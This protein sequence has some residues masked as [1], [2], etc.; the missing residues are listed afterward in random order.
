MGE[1][2]LVGRSLPFL[3]SLSYCTFWNR[4]LSIKAF[5]ALLISVCYLE[6]IFSCFIEGLIST[7]GYVSAGGSPGRQEYVITGTIGPIAFTKGWGGGGLGEGVS[8]WVWGQGSAGV[9]EG[10]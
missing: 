8:R 2:A 3:C 7:Y 5:M 4:C 1:A 9:G 10:G 6:M